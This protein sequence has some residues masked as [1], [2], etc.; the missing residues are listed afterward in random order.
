MAFKVTLE[1][2]QKGVKFATKAELIDSIWEVYKDKMSRP[3]FEA[4]IEK[5]IEEV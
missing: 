3:D 5:H 2:A 1:D 4:F